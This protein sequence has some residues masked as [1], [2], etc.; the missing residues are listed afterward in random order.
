MSELSPQE[1]QRLLAFHRQAGADDYTSVEAMKALRKLLAKHGKTWNDLPALLA[2]AEAADKPARAS[3][4]EPTPEPPPGLTPEQQAKFNALVLTRHA[5]E[6]YI[7]L[8]PHESLAVALWVL[9]T[10]VYHGFMHSPRLAVLA[11][12]K[13][14]GKSTTFRLLN[15]LAARALKCGN[16]TSASIYHVV[17]DRDPTLL[18]DEADKLD[19]YKNKDLYGILNDGHAF[20]GVI[21]RSP[22]GVFTE[23]R[24]F[25]PVAFAANGVLPGELMDR[26]VIINMK[27]RPPHLERMPLL[28]KDPADDR[29]R[30]EYTYRR[31]KQW[32]T[33]V[34]LNFYPKMPNAKNDRVLENWRPLIAIADTFGEELGKL[35]RETCLTF[36][37]LQPDEEPAVLLLRDIRT[38]F[39]DRGDPDYLWSD[40]L[41]AALLQMEGAVSWSEFRGEHN[42][43]L[44]KK[45]TPA[46]LAV[47]LERFG[48]KPKSIFPKGGRAERGPS[49]KGY[50]R[51]WFQEEWARY[52]PVDGTPAHQSNIKRLRAS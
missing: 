32:A 31:I 8:K 17:A 48:I 25:C 44:P 50:R 23:Y 51:E 10:H 18:L 34:K 26:S 7:D 3:E 5:I 16:T 42:K 6:H 28:G 33:S 19:F 4:P 35:A 52:W 11:A 13:R 9:H 21:H 1:L 14:C 20:D 22:G 29:L 24:V 47:L 30:I 2:K 43:L 46:M 49:R 15:F 40:D 39:A 27:R 41:I 37:R 12:S 45:L 36:A 38:A